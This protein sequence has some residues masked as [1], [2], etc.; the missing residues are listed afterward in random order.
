MAIQAV[1]FAVVGGLGAVVN[2]AALYVL[3]LWGRLP[4]VTATALAV[5]LA[6]VHNYLLNNRWTF[7]A[8]APSVRQFLKF[9]A[10][11]LGGLGI[12]VFVVWALVRGGMYFLL[13]N[14][15]GIGAAFAVNFASSAGWVWGRRSR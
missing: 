4:L 1:R 10:S 12:N 15:I 8:R 14:A 9:N 7:A 13:A 11:V 5:E 6:V 3:H 2:T